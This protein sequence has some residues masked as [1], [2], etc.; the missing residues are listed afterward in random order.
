MD[1][2]RIL[3]SAFGLHFSVFLWSAGVLVSPVTT[4][5]Q[6]GISTEEEGKKRAVQHI[7]SSH[8]VFNVLCVSGLGW[9]RSFG[10]GPN[11]ESG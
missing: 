3:I 8:R 1:V 5:A 9:M 11:R 10:E 2:R 6:S 4:F 7:F